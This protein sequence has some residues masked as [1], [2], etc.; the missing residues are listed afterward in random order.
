MERAEPP[1]RVLTFLFADI[2]GSTRLSQQYPDAMPRLL[3]RHNEIVC[4][5]V[6]SQNGYVYHIVGD[7]SFGKLIF[8]LNGEYFSKTTSG[9]IGLGDVDS[10]K[11]RN[12]L[13]VYSDRK[14]GKTKG[15]TYGGKV[16]VNT[17]KHMTVGDILNFWKR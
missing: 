11:I 14:V 5:A 15:Y 9:T 1:T 13:V 12:N 7:T 3:A 16:Q 4:H 2:E 8:D 6:E 17:H 10:S